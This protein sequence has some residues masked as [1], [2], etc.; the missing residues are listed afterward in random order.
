MSPLFC[1]ARTIATCI[2]VVR[3]CTAAVARTARALACWDASASCP[4]RTLN[5]S[6]RAA[7]NR[8]TSCRTGG[9][10]SSPQVRGTRKHIIMLDIVV[11]IYFWTYISRDKP[12]SSSLLTHYMQESA[13]PGFI[14]R[15]MVPKVYR[16]NDIVVQKKYT[17]FTQRTF[18]EQCT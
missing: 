9:P 13:L 3:R 12:L 17:K 14:T 4:T 2:R 11:F 1:R 16:H 15:D 5:S 10:Q 8:P 18:R 7:Q 6:P